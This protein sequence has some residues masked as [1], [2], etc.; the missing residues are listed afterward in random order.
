MWRLS[1]NGRPLLKGPSVCYVVVV[2]LDDLREIGPGH[3]PNA[4]G[5]LMP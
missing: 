1:A 5:V 2:V 4:F 3:A